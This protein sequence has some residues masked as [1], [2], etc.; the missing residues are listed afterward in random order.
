MDSFLNALHGVTRA[1]CGAVMMA[2][3]VSAIVR[4]AWMGT[5]KVIDGFQMVSLLGVLEGEALLGAKFVLDSLQFLGL[6]GTE[7][8]PK[9]IS[10][11]LAYHPGL[12]SLSILLTFLSLS[13]LTWSTALLTH[14]LRFLSTKAGS[15]FNSRPLYYTTNYIFYLLVYRVPFM[16]CYL[17][18][19]V[20]F[21][22]AAESRFGFEMIF[23]G[24]CGIYV[25]GLVGW[26]GVRLAVESKSFYDMDSKLLFLVIPLN[27]ARISRLNSMIIPV[28]II[29]KGAAAIL[30]VLLR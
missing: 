1:V 5:Y 24:V 18:V 13:L 21:R 29:F 2:V 9:P 28:T 23:G 16:A 17:A 3:L 11:L 30:V 15:W 10:R 25:A 20:V 4:N 7:P 19:V 12:P 14:L 27:P 8:S 22:V 6:A 26:V